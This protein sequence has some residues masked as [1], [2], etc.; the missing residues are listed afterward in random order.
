MDNTEVAFA[1]NAY[2]RLLKGYSH[3]LW[4]TEGCYMEE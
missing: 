1:M 2:G 4:L 3:Q